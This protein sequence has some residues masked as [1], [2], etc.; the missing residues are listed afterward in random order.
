MPKAKQT[1]FNEF[2]LKFLPFAFEK[3]MTGTYLV[4]C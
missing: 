4:M 3:I 1:F 2:E